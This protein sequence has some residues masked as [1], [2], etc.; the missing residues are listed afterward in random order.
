MNLIENGNSVYGGDRPFE[1]LIPSQDNTNAKTSSGKKQSPISFSHDTN[2]T[3]NE[4]V[5]WKQADTQKA[6]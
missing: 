1:K 5:R 4:E 6:R 2:R 3:E